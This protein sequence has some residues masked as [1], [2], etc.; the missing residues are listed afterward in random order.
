MWKDGAGYEGRQCLSYWC[1]HVDISEKVPPED[2][3]YTELS[4]T[5]VSNIVA[6]FKTLQLLIA[7]DHEK[8]IF[9][10]KEMLSHPKSVI[11]NWAKT[12]FAE[13]LLSYYG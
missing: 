10:S 8:H 6:A 4:V 2:R 7:R 12:I 1:S 13:A 11:E 3:K 5:T 9:F